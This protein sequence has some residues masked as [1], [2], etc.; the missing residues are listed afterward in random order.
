MPRRLVERQ[1]ADYPSRF[2]TFESLQSVLLLTSCQTTVVLVDGN[3]PVVDV[4]VL[5]TKNAMLETN[6]EN[7][8]GR[9]I[10]QMETDIATSYQSANNALTDSAVDFSVRVV[11]V[12]K[13]RPTTSGNDT[14]EQLVALC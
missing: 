8:V 9:S 7:A 11:H 14:P 12:Q 13:V 2:L 3:Q 10:A 1:T 5:Y 6:S 4:L